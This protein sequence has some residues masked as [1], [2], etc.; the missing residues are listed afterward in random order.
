MQQ[1]ILL[2]VLIVR[3]HPLANLKLEVCGRNVCF[4]E[5]QIWI[6]AAHIPGSENAT[7]DKKSR[8]FKRSSEWKLTQ[9]VFKQIVSK[10]GKPDTDISA[11]RIN[12]QLLNY[13]S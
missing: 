4:A 10:S 2:Q 11:S 7:A 1:Y 5:R 6:P 13:I 8:M 9:N 12:H 3:G